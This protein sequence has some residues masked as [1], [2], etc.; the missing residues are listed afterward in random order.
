MSTYVL[1]FV[2]MIAALTM[3]IE[4]CVIVLLK[5]QITPLPSRVL[6][7]LGVLVLGSQKSSQQFSGKI[8]PK[9]TRTYAVYVLILG[10]LL[11]ISSLIYLFTVML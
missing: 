10:T 2:S 11:F 5:K 1:F 6:Q 8:S 9:E 3:L 7:G 4:G